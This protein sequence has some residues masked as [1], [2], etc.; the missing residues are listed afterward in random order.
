[1]ILFYVNLWL[2]K[3]FYRFVAA[4]II[5]QTINAS[6]VEMW[7]KTWLAVLFRRYEETPVIQH[8]MP[9]TDRI[10]FHI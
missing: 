1:M 2:D 5:Q 7:M 3:R 6:A 10:R 8:P 4:S 9:A